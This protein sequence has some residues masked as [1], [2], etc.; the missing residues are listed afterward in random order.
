MAIHFSAERM[1]KVLEAHTRWWAGTLDRPL[2]K[3]VLPDAFQTQK[4]TPAPCLSQKSCTQL[5]WT[6]EQVIDALDETLG[7]QEYLGDA[8]PFVN[9]DAFGPG[10]LAALCDGAILD[11]TPGSVW[12]FPK[13]EK[14][15]CDI[16]VRYHPEN[17]WACRIRDLYRAGAQRWGGLVVM[18]MP[19]LGGVMDVLAS[20]RGTENLLLDLYDCPEEVHRLVLEIETAW[21]EAYADF[22]QAMGQEMLFSDWSGLLSA[23]PSYIIQCDFSYMISSG[24]FRT[25]V[26]DTLRR[27]TECLENTIYHLDGIGQLKHL[28]DICAMERLKAV[29]WVYG[30]GQKGPVHWLEVYRKIEKAGK[31]NMIV[32]NPEAYLETIAHLH[33]QPYS[34]HWIPAGQ[35]ALAEA[36]ILAR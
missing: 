9:F 36:V 23:K 31:Q 30:E 11:N 8:F 1:E 28:E 12:F 13:E 17:P 33:G 18:G 15:L 21:R 2:V 32:G 35:R 14:E 3:V 22:R 19:D 20:L 16:H 34:S 6:P 4:R 29:Q 7:W 10:V 25:F 26:L 5:E 24:M 27:D